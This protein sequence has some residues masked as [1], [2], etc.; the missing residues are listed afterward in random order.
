MMKSH[1]TTPPKSAPPHPFRSAA[2]YDPRVEHRPCLCPQCKPRNKPRGRAAQGL[3]VALV[4]AGGVVLPLVSVL[5][6]ANMHVVDLGVAGTAAI[7]LSVL[8]VLAHLLL[9]PGHRDLETLQVTQRPPSSTALRLALLC[10]AL[11]SSL[12]WG[13]LALLFLPILPLSFIALVVLGLGLCG[14]CPYGAL[15]ISLIHAVRDARAVRERLPRRWTVAVVSGLVLA[16]VLAM[17]GTALLRLH[18]RHNLEQAVSRIADLEPFSVARMQ[19]IS[20]LR[21][22]D[23]HI[24]DSYLATTDSDQHQVLAEVY[25]RLTDGEL[26]RRVQQRVSRQRRSLIRPWWFVSGGRPLSTDHLWRF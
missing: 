8:S 6:N 26:N 21:G 11:I 3:R 2:W 16:P 23:D 12:T 20:R 25:L 9:F 10:G 17:A 13:Y 22:Y 18:H 1:T 7:A 24:V 15:A 14:L 19:A 4:I 5:I